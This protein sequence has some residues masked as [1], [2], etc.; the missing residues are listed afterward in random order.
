MLLCSVRNI[1]ESGNRSLPHSLS[2]PSKVSNLN[3]ST[4]DLTMSSGDLV[5]CVTEDDGQETSLGHD[6]N[7]QS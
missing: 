7:Q 1:Q 4:R 5:E 6:V 3:S 2:S